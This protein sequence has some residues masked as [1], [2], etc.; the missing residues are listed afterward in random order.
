MFGSNFE[1]CWSKAKHK[2]QVVPVLWK[3]IFGLSEEDVKKRVHPT[4][5]PVELCIWFLDKFSKTKD[6]VVDIF[7]GSGSTLIACEKLGR[8]CRM[9]EIDE[10]YCDVIIRR[11]EDYTGKKAELL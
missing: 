4:Q 10:H 7:G 11:W 3:G 9:M 5:K 8:K 6:I 2:R 1:L